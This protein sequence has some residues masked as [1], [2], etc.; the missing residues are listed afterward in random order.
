LLT[1]SAVSLSP[2]EWY[3]VLPSPLIAFALSLLL[4]LLRQRESGDTRDTTDIESEIKGERTYRLFIFVSLVPL[5]LSSPTFLVVLL[6]LALSWPLQNNRTHD[7]DSDNGDEILPTSAVSTQGRR[8]SKREAH[9]VPLCLSAFMLFVLALIATTTT[10][11]TATATDNIAVL[12]LCL[13][14]LIALA[15]TAVLPRGTVS[16]AILRA[17]LSALASLVLVLADADKGK[18]VSAGDVAVVVMAAAALGL[19]QWLHHHLYRAIACAAATVAVAC[20]HGPRVGMAGVLMA[21]YLGRR[22]VVRDLLA[23]AVEN[24]LQTMRAMGPWAS[25]LLPRVASARRPDDALF[26]VGDEGHDYS[27]MTDGSIGGAANAAASLATGRGTACIWQ[28][29]EGEGSLAAAAEYGSISVFFLTS[30][31]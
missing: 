12:L 25:A 18:A 20:C 13:C 19:C 29:P 14:V 31:A 27:E 26:S 6:A 24:L 4:P 9:L 16:R 21:L 1:L 11:N 5:S 10:D 2:I 8:R 22:S 23:E 17:T 3:Y 15:C 30:V 7:Y 28:F